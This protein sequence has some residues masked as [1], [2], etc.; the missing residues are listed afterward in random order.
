MAYKKSPKNDSGFARI[1]WANVIRQ[2]YLHGVS[3]QQLCELLGV[4]SRTL[5][6]YKKDP[7][8]ITL[9]QLEALV[10]SFGTDAEALLKT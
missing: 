3:D 7:S 10:I 9:K 6:N 8:F 4:T 5:F 2:Q 1:I